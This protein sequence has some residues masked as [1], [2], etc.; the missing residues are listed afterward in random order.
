[1]ESLLLSLTMFVLEGFSFSF[2][3]VSPPV[4]FMLN[5]SLP[6]SP[7]KWTSTHHYCDHRPP[8]ASSSL[9]AINP[10]N[11]LTLCFH[12]PVY[13][14]CQEY[15]ITLCKI[16]NVNIIEHLFSAT[17]LVRQVISTLFTSLDT[18]VP[19]KTCTVT[20]SRTA[21]GLPWKSANG[22]LPL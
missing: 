2:K 13:K 12:I 1:M 9:C 6:V 11:I 19:S 22:C 15:I 8:K 7:V 16:M 4:C 14:S 18:L 21:P 3:S 17:E 10:N 20:I 5:P